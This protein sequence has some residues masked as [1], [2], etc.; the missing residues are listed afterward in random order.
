M[1]PGLRSLMYATDDDVQV[2]TRPPK[3]STGTTSSS[4][5]GNNATRPTTASPM[6]YGN[7]LNELATAELLE[8]QE[9]MMHQLEAGGEESRQSFPAAC[10]AVLK[11]LPG[12]QQCIDCGRNNPE[13]ACV[14]YGTLVC[15]YC[16]GVHRSLGVTVSTVR[17]ITMDHWTYSEVIHMLEG[18]NEQLFQFFQRHSLDA[19]SA[20]DDNTFQ[21]KHIT[22]DNVTTMRYKTKAALFY[23]QQLQHHVTSLLQ[24]GPY[25]GRQRSSTATSTSNRQRRRPIGTTNSSS[26]SC[27]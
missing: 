15:L 17:S 7:S 27:S 18:G 9:S 20:P 5:T 22:R 13:W 6:S 25:R 21:S 3:S 4:S 1:T 26:M 8:L 10:R 11:S 23:R 16:S 24:Q 14:S 12:N 2:T 19:A